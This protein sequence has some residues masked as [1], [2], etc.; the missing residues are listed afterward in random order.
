MQVHVAESVVEN[1]MDKINPYQKEFLGVSE[2][3]VIFK[4]ASGKEDLDFESNR[5]GIRAFIK[6]FATK[7]IADFVHQKVIEDY[8]RKVI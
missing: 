2:I 5:E 3:F 4:I 1:L 8:I 7:E 6:R